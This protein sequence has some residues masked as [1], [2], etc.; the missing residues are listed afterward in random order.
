MRSP[1]LLLLALILLW[2]MSGCGNEQPQTISLT[3]PQRLA[4]PQYTVLADKPEEVEETVPV[5]NNNRPNNNTVRPQPQ[6]V[7]D[8]CPPVHVNTI[9][10]RQ[11]RINK[12]KGRL[13]SLDAGSADYNRMQGQINEQE[14]SLKDYISARRNEGY[15]CDPFN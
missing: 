10:A 12:L 15:N 7:S 3:A 14:Q 8:R 6:P 13:E 11:K 2:V 5:V 1:V 4:K 9:R